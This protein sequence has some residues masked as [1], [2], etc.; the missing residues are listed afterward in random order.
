VYV[1]LY[2]FWIA[3]ET[4]RVTQ[5]AGVYCLQRTAIV[6]IITLFWYH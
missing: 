3:V 2:I 1:Y 5:Y 4:V 6:Q